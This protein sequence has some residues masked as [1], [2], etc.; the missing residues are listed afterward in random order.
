MTYLLARNMQ[1]IAPK[2]RIVPNIPNAKHTKAALRQKIV[3]NTPNAR[4]LSRKRAV[5]PDI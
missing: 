5:N 3:K 2:K 1:I 4:R